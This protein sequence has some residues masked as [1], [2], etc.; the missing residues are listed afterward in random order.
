MEQGS[1]NEHRIVNGT[2]LENIRSVFDLIRSHK[3]MTRLEL[4]EKTK[5]SLPTITRI[6]VNLQDLNLIEEEKQASA[7]LGRRT[8]VLKV[9]PSAKYSYGIHIDKKSLNLGI[10]GLNNSIIANKKIPFDSYLNSAK[11]VIEE[12]GIR[13]NELATQYQIPLEQVVSVGIALPGIINP[14]EGIQEFSPQLGWKGLPLRSL[15]TEIL[16]LPVIIENDLN[17]HAYGESL[18]GVEGNPFTAV[19]I[20]IGSGVGAAYVE[21]NVVFKGSFNSAGEIGHTKIDTGGILCDCGGTGCLQTHMSEWAI[22]N[23]ARKINPKVTS[24]KEVFD[25]MNEGYAWASSIIFDL[26]N[27]T[28]IAFGLLVALYDPHVIVVGG[29]L[30]DQNPAF[31]DY[32]VNRYSDTESSHMIIKRK[33]LKSRSGGKSVFYGAAVLALNHFLETYGFC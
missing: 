17:C 12:S 13:L 4:S 8:S 19:F 24:S 14:T 1:T 26:I 11:K 27:Y 9:S 32:L 16:K 30:I 3:T 23:K 33:L 25:Y 20:N 15:A 31:F 6:I 29:E 18:L 5:L 10:V 28:S 7:G 2:K 21:N 22:V